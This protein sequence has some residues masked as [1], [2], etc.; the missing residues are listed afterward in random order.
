MLP[1]AFARARLCQEHSSL[2]CFFHGD[3]LLILQVSGWC[4]FLQEASP[5]PYQVRWPLVHVSCNTHLLQPLKHGLGIAC[6]LALCLSLPLE[7]KLSEDKDCVP[8]Y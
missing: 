5:D 1:W 8:V 4:C 7:S 2:P 3:L 6:E